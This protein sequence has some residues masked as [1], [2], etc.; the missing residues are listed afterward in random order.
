PLALLGNL[1]GL[2]A[3]LAAD[4][5]RQGAQPALR[6]FLT[7]LE[8][9]PEGAFLQPAEGL[10]DLR[11][12]F[13]LHLDEGELDVILDV[14]LGRL[15]RVAHAVGWAGGPLGTDRA[16]LLVHGAHDLAAAF[17]EDVLELRIPIPIHLTSW[18]I[19]DAHMIPFL[20]LRPTR[21]IK[22]QAVMQWFCQPRNPV[23]LH[24]I[25]SPPKGRLN[26][27][28]G[29]LREVKWTRV[30]NRREHGPRS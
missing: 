30:S 28:G 1:A 27:V 16:D 11:E 21:V 4:G 25:C 17:L 14:R 29:G 18:R 9:V 8:A 12:R 20:S 24:Q 5:E 15:G 19:I 3:V 7:A 10:F 22:S 6:D 23:S 2:L 26:P 13:R